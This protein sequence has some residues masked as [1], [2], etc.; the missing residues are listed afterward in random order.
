[1]KTIVISNGILENL[2][3][4]QNDLDQADLIL[5]ADGGACNARA[6]GMVPHVLV[7]DS[8]SLDA[9][10]ARWLAE[11]GTRVVR[12]P[13]DKDETDLELALLYAVEAGAT[14]IAILGAWGGRPDQA[15]ANL[16]LLAHPR[17]A[18][19]R[20]R[21]LG[22]GYEM[23]LLRGGEETSLATAPGDTVS[24]IPLAG[25]AHGVHTAGLR[26]ALDG[27]TLHFGPARGVSNQATAPKV[28]VQLEEGLLLVVHLISTLSSPPYP[29]GKGGGEE[30]TGA[31][32]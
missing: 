7:G 9:E 29:L 1:V 32:S 11:H 2:A 13:A 6:L 18:G 19:R 27:D 23:L 30:L 5:A 20:A 3:A 15:V 12:H 8:D 25:D 26:W 31:F 16:H 22:A 17:L 21:I 24:L 10:T 14:E 28:R 4:W